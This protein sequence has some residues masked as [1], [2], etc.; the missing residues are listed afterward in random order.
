[1]VEFLVDCV[2]LS[3]LFFLYVG[4]DCFGLIEVK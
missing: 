3:E 4:I 2:I 1:M